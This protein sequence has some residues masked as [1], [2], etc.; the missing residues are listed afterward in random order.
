MPLSVMVLSS[1]PAALSGVFL[2]IS[3]GSWHV[4]WCVCVCA[5]VHRLGSREVVCFGAAD[6]ELL[7]CLGYACWSGDFIGPINGL[8]GLRLSA[9]VLCVMRVCVFGSLF[10]ST[11][12][13]INKPHL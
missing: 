11:C 2:E 9:C 8:Y 6:S 10:Y 3:V 7:V 13:C 1:K 12:T 5:F 4:V